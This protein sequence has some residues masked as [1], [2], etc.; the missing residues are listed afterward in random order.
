MVLISCLTRCRD[1]GDVS[2]GPAAPR[3]SAW[4]RQYIY[5][6]GRGRPGVTPL[7][8]D[9]GAIY[10]RR[11]WIQL[12]TVAALLLLA[13]L[14]TAGAAHQSAP[15]VSRRITVTR[16]ERRGHFCRTRVPYDSKTSAT[17]QGCRLLIRCGDVEVNP[18][19]T[20]HSNPVTSQRRRSEP[21]TCMVQN[22]RSL[23]NKFGSLRALS[24]ALQGFDVIALT[25]TWLKP[26]VSDSEL[27]HGF[28]SH[29]W[30]RHDRGGDAAGGGV[31]CALR[32]S[33]LPT[34]RP[35][36]EAGEV[37]VIDLMACSPV[38]TVITA[39][40]PPDDDAAVTSIVN[41]MNTVCATERSV[42]MVGDFNLPEIDWCR[43]DDRPVL[44]RRSGRA[45]TFVDT[46]AQCGLR[47]HVRH[48]TRGDNVLDLVLTNMD[49]SRCDVDEGLFDSDHRHIVVTCPCPACLH[50]VTRSTALNYRRA[51]FPAL[52]QS[53]HLLP[54]HILDGLE[55]DAAV[56]LFYQWTEAAVADHIPRVTF[57]C[58]YPP[59]FDSDVKRALR[60]KEL[61]H[62]RKKLSPT[63]EN[64]ADFSLKRSVFNPR[65][66]GGPFERPPLR[67]FEASENTAA[68]SAAGFSPTLPPSFPQLL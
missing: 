53:L 41:I 8:P 20:R 58:K 25:E 16:A 44:L 47:Q 66:A 32:A 6:P 67:F 26:Y 17:Y 4:V 49:V 46:A 11:E 43:P 50:R 36:L 31:A 1:T 52:R 48:P 3:S 30:F 65:P 60:E 54:L 42:L 29:V 33:L 63:S 2:V 64:N 5:P 19:P 21:L 13:L 35:E 38:V 24:P 7:G 55:V 9:G 68:R 34:R 62:R 39:Y 56:D 14:S 57:K 18:G 27:R 28:D 40:R 51:D 61:A 22:V 10:R 15:P 45:V 12:T 59:W 37:L 23:K